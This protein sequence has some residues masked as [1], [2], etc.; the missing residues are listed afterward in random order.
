MKKILTVLLLNLIC[1]LCAVG[2]SACGGVEFKINFIVDG[3]VYA[4]VNTNGAETI[5][6]PDNPVKD[7]Y[8]FDGWFWDKDTWQK[9][10]TANSLL[11]TPLS[12]NMSVYA[13]WTFT[14][15]VVEPDTTPAGIEE[16]FAKQTDG[17]YYGKV[18]N[19]T[20]SF[21]FNGKIESQS[22]FYVCTDEACTKP[23][24]NNTA[25]LKDRK[26]VV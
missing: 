12:S 5:K 10:F 21:D 19:T 8:T 24:N 18:Y 2:F 23:L 6:M 22:D 15:E 16:Y 7:D 20:D 13:K 3:D 25:S 4:T 11:D 1:V 17:T 9:P 14:G 26:S